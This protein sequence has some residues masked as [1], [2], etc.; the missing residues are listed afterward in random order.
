MYPMIKHI[1]LGLFLFLVLT[2]AGAQ[3]NIR[4]ISLEEV[5]ELGG[6]NH[7]TIQE[8]Q[9]RQALALADQA[10]AREWWLPDLQAGISTHQLSGAAMNGNGRF[11]LDV[12]RDNL[13]G[14]LGLDA[15]W[16]PGDGIFKA[17]AASLNAQAAQYTTAAERNKA[18]LGSIELY[19]DFLL[20]QL[21]QQSYDRLVLEADT[22]ARQIGIQVQAGSRYSSDELL[23]K[24]NL[25][26]LKIKML[27]AKREQARTSAALAGQLQVEAGVQ[28]IGTDSVLAPLN[29][30]VTPL[31]MPNFETAWQNRPEFKSRQLKL[32]ALQ[33]EKKTAT[34]GL[35]LPEIRVGTYAAYFG[36]LNNP[37]TPMDPIAYPQTNQLYPTYELNLAV[38]WRIPLGSIFYG[39]DLKQHRAKIQIAETQLAQLQTG[40]RVELISAREQIQLADQQRQIAEEGSG[41]AKEALEQCIAREALGTARPFEILQAQEMFLKSRLD[42]LRAVADYNVAQYR[43]FVALGN[44][45]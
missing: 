10:K 11:F 34:V 38:T 31:E 37:L 26:Q 45:L 6:A 22:L 30:Q 29:L 12:K 24:S 44:N 5:L 3:E 13:W 25:S 43:L 2:T 17:K 42:Y 8:Y 27:Q 20:A 16:K 21:M 36:D 14:G 41:Y 32:S 18:L 39:G 28:L 40:A 15:R 35:L 19:Y 33:T 23:A 1:A 7:L 4:A 9:Q